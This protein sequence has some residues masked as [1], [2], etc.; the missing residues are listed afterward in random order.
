MQESK[1]SLFNKRCWENWSI[2]CKRKKL[3]YFVTPHTKINSNWIRDLNVKLDTMNSLLLILLIT[4]LLP[5][6]YRHCLN[7]QPYP[8]LSPYLMILSTSMSS[9]IL[10]HCSYIYTS[11]LEGS[12]VF[13]ILIF[14]Y[15]PNRTTLMSSHISKSEL[16]S[17]FLKRI[18]LLQARVLLFS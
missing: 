4:S 6:N 3:E 11:S 7:S 5:A 9:F 13:Q 8:F 17:S 18:L 2:I 15:L 10:L 12:P 16:I 14:N 1:D